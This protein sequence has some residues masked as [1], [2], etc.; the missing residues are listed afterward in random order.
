MDCIV[1]LKYHHHRLAIWLRASN[2]ANNIFLA[3]PRKIL[4]LH[5]LQAS[6]SGPF[7]ILSLSI[8][9]TKSE[10]CCTQST[11]IVINNDV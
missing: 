1:E 5:L 10:D 2:S 7:V 11:S 9:S 3:D 6:Y 8:V 4:H